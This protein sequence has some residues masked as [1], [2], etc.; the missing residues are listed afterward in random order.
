MLCE[1]V[2]A[3]IPLLLLYEV[4]MMRNFLSKLVHFAEL[5]F[6][7]EPVEMILAPRLQIIDDS[8]FVKVNFDL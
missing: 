2:N 6:Q 7:E 8:T 5:L 4:E 1:L 3:K